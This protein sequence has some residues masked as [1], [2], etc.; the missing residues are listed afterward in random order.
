MNSR[1]TSSSSST[2]LLSTTSNGRTNWSSN[3]SQ[4]LQTIEDNVSNAYYKYGLICS[5]HPVVVIVST[6]IIVSI[7]CYPLTGIRY[8]LGNSSQK[9]IT[10]IDNTFPSEGIDGQ[11][12]GD[13]NP[14]PNWFE[15]NQSFAFIQQIVVKSSVI[16]WK[17]NLI[18]MDA[19]RAPL[20]QS[21][22]LMET[23]SNY[24]F[25]NDE[26]A[27]SL[28][29]YCFQISE[30]IAKMVDKQS[31]SFLPMYSCLALSPAN[32]WQNDINNFL[33]DSTIVKTMYSIKD[34]AS[35]HSSGSLRDIL[36]GIPWME[37]GI[38]RLY[39]RTRQRTITFAITL[40]MST[41][42][43]QYI[44]G[45]TAFLKEKYSLNPTPN[46]NQTANEDSA[47]EDDEPTWALA[48]CSVLTVIMSLLMS[49]G[50]CL[51]LGFNPTLN[52]THILPYI[53][54]II[55]LENMLV[56]T[57]SVVSTPAHL[58]IKVRVA[59]GLSREGW[60]ITKNLMTEITLLTFGFFT[61]VPMIQLN[62]KV[63]SNGHTNAQKTH[64]RHNSSADN[65][66][67]FGNRTYG[68]N[69][70]AR[71]SKPSHFKMPK[72]L[73][74]VYFVARTRL[75][76]RALM[77]VLIGWISFLV[78]NFEI[79]E[80]LSR[81][82]Q[83][84]IGNPFFQSPNAR[85]NQFVAKSALNSEHINQKSSKTEDKFDNNS[86]TTADMPQMHRLVHHNPNLW[87]SLSSQHWSALFNYYNLSLSGNYI[88]I[89]PPILLSIPVSPESTVQTRN[90]AESDPQ[91][92][93]QFLSPPGLQSI[94]PNDEKDDNFNGLNTDSIPHIPMQWS[95]AEIFITVALSVPSIIFIIYV[96]VLM[97][98]CMCSR[99][100]AEWRDSWSQTLK[101]GKNQTIK[102]GVSSYDFIDFETN[103]IRLQD[104]EQEL[105]HLASNSDTPFV[106]SICT[107]GDLRVWDVLSGECHTYIKRFISEQSVVRKRFQP[108]HKP[109]GSFSSD[110]TYGSSPGNANDFL[111][112]IP[113]NNLNQISE[114]QSPLIHRTGSAGSSDGYNF[115]PYLSQQT[116][117]SSQNL[118]T[119]LIL[120]AVVNSEEVSPNEISVN[121]KT[122]SSLPFEPIWCSD[123]FGKLVIIGCRSGRLEVWDALN[124]NL[125][126]FYDDN[127]SGVTA[128]KATNTK[129]VVARLNGTLEIFNLEIINGFSVSISS[130]TSQSC[131][132]PAKGQ[133]I[134]YNLM[135]SI[136]A[137]LQPITALQIESS[138]VITGGLDHLLKVYRTDTANCLFTLHGHCGGITAI[139]IDQ[140]SPS[141][142]ISGCQVGQV[143]VWDV[144]TGTCVFSL[145]AHMDASVTALIATPLYFISSG[146]DNRICHLV[147]C[148]Q[149]HHSFCK[150]LLLLTPN[151]LVTARE[152]HL[153]LFDI[154]EAIAIRIIELDANCDKQNYIKNLKISSQSRAVVCD[155][156]KQLCVIHF[157][158]VT[159][160]SD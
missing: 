152:D 103:P 126:F 145:E 4:F 97:Y 11:R 104:H 132:H 127:K 146:T 99:N 7:C 69:V 80:N 59:Q 89:L 57:K 77:L 13:T 26:R 141:T 78:Y 122:E 49:L 40:V 109:S 133:V 45:L 52:A 91:I 58:D 84:S 155:Y 123:I 43:Q 138:N 96:F 131:P 140:Y 129:L 74:V 130:S 150:E 124:G 30:P 29:N 17:D 159:E 34:L 10:S 100:Y 107:D 21:F 98:R 119:E 144:M 135:H 3:S 44:D 38:K 24:Q 121:L 53:V 51:R 154:S 108:T 5:R 70:F 93:R 39:V 9:F 32:I 56:L 101:F 72:R 139:H 50:I 87:K 128:L 92:F 102:K 114:K 158:S 8:L 64:S 67:T 71:P 18:L 142:A 41:Q 148:I 2:T 20:S 22:K 35:P 160:K 112:E 85:N 47:Q 14:I 15:T 68:Q 16:P 149:N 88:T 62:N 106:L 116:S 151:I 115:S 156:G 137:H 134:R 117:Y 66:L 73:R 12:S 90:P 31:A 36:F 118:L 82:S 6:L 19:I 157:P 105:N 147:H 25:L 143:C 95:S 46:D 86:D 27:E 60:S 42:S 110:S 75:V 1:K 63:N 94:D 55:G 113:N 65:G 83:H 81:D 61:F 136:R 79:I 125:C 153:V 37:T 23:I 111:T 28:N 120:N 54:I 33:M 76:Q 48:L